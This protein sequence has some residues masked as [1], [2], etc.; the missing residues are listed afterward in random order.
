MPSQST[1]F[2]VGIHVLALLELYKDERCTSDFIAASVGTNPV[3]I[4][5]M[6]K[7]LADAGFIRVHAGVGGAELARPPERIRLLDVY[8][9][10]EPPRE[11]GLFGMHEHPHP[12]CRVGSTI[13]ASLEGVFASAQRAVE[14]ELHGRTLRDVVID[15][16]RRG[17]TC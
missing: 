5:R 4:R 8:R 10:V 15:L 6:T 14:A 7:L 11:G 1:R 9:A 13:R 2:A 12:R 17:R 3:V 16:E